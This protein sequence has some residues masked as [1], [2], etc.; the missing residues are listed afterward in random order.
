MSIR[1]YMR[2]TLLDDSQELNNLDPV[3]GEEV[4]EEELA[5]RTPEEDAQAAGEAIEELAEAQATDIVIEQLEL[6]ALRLED[7]AEILDNVESSDKGHVALART[8]ADLVADGDVDATDS[9][10]NPDGVSAESMVGSRLSTEGFKDAAQR[11]WNAIKEFVKKLWSKIEGFFYKMFG[12]IPRMR[13][14]LEGVKKRLVEAE[15]KGYT[16]PN[17]ELTSGTSQMQSANNVMKS[18]GEYK[19]G[20]NDMQKVVNEIFVTSGKAM[21]DGGEAIANAIEAYNPDADKMVASLAAI[22][23]AA[24]KAVGN[25]LSSI[26]STSAPFSTNLDSSEYKLSFSSALPGNIAIMVKSDSG[27]ANIARGTSSTLAGAAK[28]RSIGISSVSPANAKEAPKTVKI[29]TPKVGEIRDAIAACEKMLSD[30]EGFYRGTAFKKIKENNKKIQSAGD[31]LQKQVA[32]LNAED[33]TQDVIAHYRA[34]LSFNSS[35]TSGILKSFTGLTSVAMTACSF[36]AMV[37]NKTASAS[38]EKK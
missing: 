28:A 33:A 3:T 8:V 13:K 34:A 30:M 25:K 24:T 10:I 15:G 26:S 11:I 38:R 27:A 21:A 4:N 35:Y 18:F 23:L 12:R 32:K 19:A 20:L 14:T 6:K 17:I 1:N 7:A 29:A 22:S 2:L 36:V 5:E 31:K 16:E 9:V 37:G